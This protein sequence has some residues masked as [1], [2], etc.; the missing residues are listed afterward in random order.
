MTPPNTN[1]YQFQNYYRPIDLSDDENNDS[2]VLKNKKNTLKRGSNNSI[3]SFFE[4]SKK[5][6]KTSLASTIAQ[7]DGEGTSCISVSMDDG[8]TP[9][10]LVKIELYEM[11]KLKDIAPTDYWKHAAV[12]VKYYAQ[13][14]GDTHYQ[15]TRDVIYN[16]TKLIAGKKD[17]KKYF[18]ETDN[19]Q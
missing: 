6:K 1:D 15:N 7:A 17:C 10:H 19:K 11:K 18:F 9:S 13:S 3:E 5:K 4:K 12:R 8:S 2:I 14:E 16:I